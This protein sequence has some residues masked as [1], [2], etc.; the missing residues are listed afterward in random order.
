MT[1]APH[2][3]PDGSLVYFSAARPAAGLS[4]WQQLLGVK[5]AA[6]HNIPSSWWRV[7]V[8]GG[9]PELIADIDEIGLHGAFSPD[10]QLIAY[11]SNTGL[12]MMNPDGTN[13]QQLLATNALNGLSWVP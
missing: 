13:R 11:I 7:P 5:T 3:S 10:G 6:A 9:E 8:T 12:Y 1:F 2:F 4:W